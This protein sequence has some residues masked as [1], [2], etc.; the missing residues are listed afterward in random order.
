MELKS[1]FR[2]SFSRAS[3]CGLK[4]CE[5]WNNLPY[6]YS[7][8]PE[9]LPKFLSI[10]LKYV[11][12]VNNSTVDFISKDKKVYDY[13]DLIFL[14]KILAKYFKIQLFHQKLCEISY[15]TPL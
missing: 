6:F 12:I 7:H 4:F 5:Y 14:A 1:F 8:F 3:Y 10:L 9:F 15:F 13:I 11:K 2:I